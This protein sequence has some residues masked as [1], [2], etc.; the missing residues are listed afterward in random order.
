L[1]VDYDYYDDGYYL[2]DRSYPDVAARGNRAALTFR[3]VSKF[4]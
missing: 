4:V 1:Y 2:V 3:P